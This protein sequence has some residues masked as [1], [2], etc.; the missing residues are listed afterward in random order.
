MRH[1]AFVVPGDLNSLTGGYGYDREILAGL[2]AAGWSIDVVQLDA[3]YPWPSLDARRDAARKIDAIADGTTVVVDGL[4]F[5]AMPELARRHAARLRWMALVHHP[6]ALESGLD[7]YQSQQ[8]FDSER[9]ALAAAQLVVTTSAATARA[10]ADYGVTDDRIR[11]VPPGTMRAAP[12]ITSVDTLVCAGAGLSLLC[13][14]TLTPRKGHALLFE[15]LAALQD[16]DWTLHCVGS[17]MPD[18]G[19]TAALRAQLAHHGLASRVHLHG[20]FPA[21][22][23]Q[24]LYARADVF[25][26]ASYHEGY[27]M[28]LAEALAHGLP[29]VST[30]AGAIPDT[31]PAAAGVLVPPGD[32]MA[33]RAALA[34]VLDDRAYRGR[35]AAGARAASAC[36]PRWSDAVVQFAAAL[37]ALQSPC[38]PHRR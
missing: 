24:A 6:L 2:R 8:L 3:G 18:P 19:T 28:A 22:A 31:V 36:L 12:V 27:G 30:T 33:L 23:L 10:L 21:P 17:T 4:A 14:A 37:D 15:A 16:R 11:V 20:E 9:T 5:G 13:V 25:V 29:I 7:A 26:L 1:A 34:K 38:E 32:T 35:L